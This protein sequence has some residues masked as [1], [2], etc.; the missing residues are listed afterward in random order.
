LSDLLGD[1][2]NAYSAVGA[3]EDRR[4]ILVAGHLA[5]IARD[6][7]L[8]DLDVRHLLGRCKVRGLVVGRGFFASF[9]EE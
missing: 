6:Q 3:F 8:I 4:F 5:I 9:G 1:F 7:V 2:V